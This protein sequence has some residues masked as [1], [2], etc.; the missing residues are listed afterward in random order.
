MKETGTLFIYSCLSYLYIVFHLHQRALC[1]FFQLCAAILQPWNTV[2]PGSAVPLH[3]IMQMVLTHCTSSLYGSP[4]QSHTHLYIWENPPREKDTQHLRQKHLDEN[5]HIAKDLFSRA[6]GANGMQF[7]TS[8]YFNT[9][10]NCVNK[11]CKTTKLI[12]NWL[13]HHNSQTLHVTKAL[14]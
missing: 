1:R 7:E 14:P 3:K 8:I 4:N 12:V 2:E 13:Y 11:L 6:Y 10:D 5:V 9:K